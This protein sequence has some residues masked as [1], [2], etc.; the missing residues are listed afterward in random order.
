VRQP[1]GSFLADARAPLEDVV[2]T[3]GPEFDI[4]D[5]GDEVDTLGGYVMTRAGRLPTRGQV[6]PGPGAFEIEVLDSDPRRLK[7]VRITRGSPDRS[8]RSVRRRDTAPTI[9]PADPEAPP[10]K[11]VP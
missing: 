7:K 3:V 5:I 10:G 4:G 9:V 8:G 6:V 2:A 11:D 1:D